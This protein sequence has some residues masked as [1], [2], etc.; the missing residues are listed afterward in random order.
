MWN[1]SK[2]LVKD[3][4]RRTCRKYPAEEKIRIALEGFLDE[5]GIA[6]PGSL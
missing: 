5:E 2:K 4:R 3:I 6:V 1:S